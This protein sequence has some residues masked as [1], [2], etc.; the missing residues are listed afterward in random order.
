[1]SILS[2]PHTHTTYCDGNATAREMVEAAVARGF[3]S[4]G[5]SG[6]SYTV[7]DESYAMSP[8]GMGR[9]IREIRGLQQEYKDKLDILLGVEWD[10]Y[11]QIDR[12][13]YDF[14]IGSVHYLKSPLTGDHYTVD[15]TREEL[16]SCLEEGFHGNV[17]AMLTTYYENVTD[18]AVNRK[19]TILG[20]FDLIRKL[21]GDGHF[22]D[23]TSPAYLHLAGQAI[24][25]AAAAGAVLEV[26]T[27]GVYRGYRSTPYPAEPL[28]RRFC[29]LG[30]RV[31][32]SSDAHDTEA[33]DFHFDETER[34]LA[35]IGFKEVQILTSKGFVPQKLK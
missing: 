31:I 28:L 22:F 27:G 7:F 4:L 34:M 1:M 18:M 9:Y 6:H 2:N 23:E 16:E 14:I 10:Y 26:N 8:G 20:H 21:N 13:D 32:V 11:G 3:T 5:F 15:Y 29:K 12:E 19:P 25:K 24:E 30:G 33:L 35:D 17:M